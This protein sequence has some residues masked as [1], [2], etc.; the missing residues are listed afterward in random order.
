M[1]MRLAVAAGPCLLFRTPTL[2]FC[3]SSSARGMSLFSVGTQA[4]PAGQALRGRVSAG[5]ARAS[6]GHGR[7]RGALAFSAGRG[8]SRV[9][10]LLRSGVLGGR[11]MNL[12]AVFSRSTVG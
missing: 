9:A 3:K 1:S 11:R 7:G 8:S 2:E 4:V 5:G 6:G 10:A 12:P